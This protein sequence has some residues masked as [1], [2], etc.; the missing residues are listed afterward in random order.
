MC[1]YYGGIVNEFGKTVLTRSYV[2]E[3]V[4][5]NP[6]AGADIWGKAAV[7]YVNSKNNVVGYVADNIT[8][9]DGVDNNRVG[10]AENPIKPFVGAA[11]GNLTVLNEWVIDESGAVL[12]DAFAQLA[13]E[14]AIELSDDLETVEDNWFDF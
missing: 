12:D 8:L 13:D 5:T 3:N 7:N 10:T 4:S 14:L 1:G 2:A 6:N 9:Y 11:A